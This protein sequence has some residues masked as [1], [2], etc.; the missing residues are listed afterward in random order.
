M[1]LYLED[2]KLLVVDGK[3]AVSEDCCCGEECA[4]CT[5]GISGLDITI[6]G[7]VKGIYWCDNCSQ[8]N[9]TYRVPA[10]IIQPCEGSKTFVNDCDTTINFGWTIFCNANYAWFL[11]AWN[12]TDQYGNGPGGS[13]TGPQAAR[14]VACLDLTYPAT[15]M[16]WPYGGACDWN[17]AMI[18]A[19]PY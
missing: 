7:V 13:I 8:H 5:G 3:L 2:G 10:S 15:N 9:T 4:C 6:S 17:N 1:P 19:V 16:L 14:P 18:S 12:I 11:I